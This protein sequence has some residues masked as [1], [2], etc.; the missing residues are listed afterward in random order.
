MAHTPRTIAIIGLGTFG[1]SLALE[2]TRFGDRVLGIDINAARV[3]EMSDEIDA[4]LEADTSD[5][6]TLKECG[7]DAFDVVVV[8]IGRVM[9]ASLLTALNL[10][11]AEHNHIWVKAQSQHH[12]TLLR[13]IGITNI[14]QPEGYF[15]Y[16]LAQVLHNPVVKD[17]L[18]LSKGRFIVQ[19]KVPGHL[20][21]HVLES[22]NL[23]KKFDLKCIGVSRGEDML[24]S[25]CETTELKA[26]DDILMYGS[27]PNLR[28]F[29]DSL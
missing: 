14:V 15:G 1:K 10:L 3:A 20:V 29:A 16:R 17:F 6:K 23:Q 7:I 22:L 8:A 2:L 9:D 4:T 18:H 28:R 5:P 19:I 21:G 11:K 26:G 25:N 27:R 13:A 24:V 12:E